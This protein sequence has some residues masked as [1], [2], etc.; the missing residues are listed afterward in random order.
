MCVACVDGDERDT[1]L[2]AFARSRMCLN[3]GQ[4]F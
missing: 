1:C 2:D 4:A 3:A